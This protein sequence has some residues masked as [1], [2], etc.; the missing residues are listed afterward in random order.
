[1]WFGGEGPRSLWPV[2]F[3]EVLFILFGITFCCSLLTPSKSLLAIWQKLFQLVRIRDSWGRNIARCFLLASSSQISG[4]NL[5]FLNLK[6]SFF[7]CNRRKCWYSP[8]LR[9]YNFFL[10]IFRTASSIRIN[11]VPVIRQLITSSAFLTLDSR[12][13]TLVEA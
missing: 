12:F 7:S 9:C 4:E 8:D 6:L 10:W 13:L 3:T 11:Y 1:M 2:T 5:S